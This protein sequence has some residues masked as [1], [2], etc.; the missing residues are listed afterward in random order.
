MS[1]SRERVVFGVEV[2]TATISIANFSLESGLE[3]VGVARSRDTLGLEEVADGVVGD[4]FLVC[5]FRSFVN[6]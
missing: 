4:V 2:H 6:L 3:A 5:Q 1:N